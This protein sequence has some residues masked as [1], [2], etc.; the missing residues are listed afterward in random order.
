MGGSA[1]ISGAAPNSNM[2]SNINLAG[3]TI[4][5]EQ[6]YGTQCSDPYDTWDKV[7]VQAIIRITLK[8][9]EITINVQR[10]N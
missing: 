2:N 4:V 10:R 5:A 6:C 3:S 7:V 9:Y 1:I 8:D